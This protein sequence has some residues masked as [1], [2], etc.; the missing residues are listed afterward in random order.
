V[1]HASYRGDGREGELIVEALGRN[2]LRGL[3]V[4]ELTSAIESTDQVWPR[5]IRVELDYGHVTVSLPLESRSYQKQ[6]LDALLP[7]LAEDLNG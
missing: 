1:V 4:A 6:K 7:S 5:V 2:S 3:R